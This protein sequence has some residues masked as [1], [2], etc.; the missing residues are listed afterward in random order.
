MTCLQNNQIQMKQTTNFGDYLLS[1]LMKMLVVDKVAP[2]TNS[3]NK[4]SINYFLEV[5]QGASS[6]QTFIQTFH[7]LLQIRQTIYCQRWTFSSQQAVVH[8]NA[9]SQT[10]AFI[11]MHSFF[12]TQFKFNL[13]LKISVSIQ[14]SLNCLYSTYFAFRS[15]IIS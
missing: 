6:S 11:D 9:L 8:Q 13:L 15:K 5:S 14:L 10:N 3:I 12:K 7:L 2:S 4:G 1:R